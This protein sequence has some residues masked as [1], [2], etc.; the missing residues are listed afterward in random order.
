MITRGWKATLNYG[1]SLVASMGL[2]WAALRWYPPLAYG[3]VALVA[4]VGIFLHRMAGHFLEDVQVFA[5]KQKRL[6]AK[7]WYFESVITNSGNIIF[8]TDVEHRILKFNRGSERTFGLSQTDVLGKEVHT[9]FESPTEISLLLARVA[10][11]GSAEAQELRI[12]PSGSDEEIWLSMSV[13]RMHDGSLLFL[14]GST[15]AS[16]DSLASGY[17]YTPKP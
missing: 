6:D 5:L 13:T 15:G 12:K 14:G 11:H 1:L 7:A 9:L 2:L 4:A 10:E 17:V 3:V 16:T 8:T